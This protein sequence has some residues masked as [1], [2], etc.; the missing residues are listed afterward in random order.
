MRLLTSWNLESPPIKYGAPFPKWGGGGIFL[1]APRRPGE[2]HLRM[3]EV[4]APTVHL[5]LALRS[6]SGMS[7]HGMCKPLAFRGTVNGQVHFWTK[8]N[9]WEA[10]VCWH[11][12]VN[13][14]IPR[15]F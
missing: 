11:L 10:V 13:R 9:Q 4:L 2:R 1:H 5:R 6:I 8:L 15:V 7:C 3:L 14:I 12:Q